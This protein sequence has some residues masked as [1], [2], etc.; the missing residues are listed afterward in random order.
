MTAVDFSQF[1]PERAAPPPTVVDYAAPDPSA[2]KDVYCLD[3]Q[4]WYTVQEYLDALSAK[5]EA[6]RECLARHA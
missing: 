2:G 6:I 1:A 4:R 5:D 3:D